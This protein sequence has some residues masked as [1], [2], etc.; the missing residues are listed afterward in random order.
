MFDYKSM[1]D[2]WQFLPVILKRNDKKR[3]PIMVVFFICSN[4]NAQAGRI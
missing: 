1:K 3:P 2:M 4:T